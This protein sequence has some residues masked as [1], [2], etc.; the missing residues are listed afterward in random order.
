MVQFY[1]VCLL[2][3]F[4]V[5]CAQV[6]SPHERSLHADSLAALKGWKAS[7]IP[8]GHFEFVVYT[9]AH[10]SSAKQLTIYIEG[11]G[12]A[13]INRNTPSTDPTPRDPMALRLAL[14]HPKGV[15]VYL[16][17][18]CQYIDAERAGCNSTYWTEKRFAPEIIDATNRTIDMLKLR[19]NTT[20]LEL[21]GYSGG[22]NI[23]VL[24]A[25][26]R[27]DIVRLI[28]VAGNIDHRAWT[29]YHHLSP[30]SGSLNAAD[31]A[32]RIAN[33]PQIHYI[34][35]KDH[36]IPSLLAQRWPRTIIGPNSDNLHIIKNADHSCCWVDQWPILYYGKQNLTINNDY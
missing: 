2:A 16:A 15:A 31:L 21:V 8:A 22:G 12:F 7:R 23:A 30:L 27:D 3:L 14:A 19:F 13:W 17:R 18:P 1:P 36:V 33:L 35:G 32:D 10:V 9:A 6:P 24:V 20:Q 25:A 34:G 26:H 4:L 28:T 11:D 29:T 5:S